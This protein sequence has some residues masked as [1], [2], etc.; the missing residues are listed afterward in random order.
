M[1]ALATQAF[2]QI[3]SEGKL[4]SL[5]VLQR[6]TAAAGLARVVQAEL[7]VLEIIGTAARVVASAAS[8]QAL[9]TQVLVTQALAMQVLAQQAPA[10]I[11]LVGK[12]AQSLPLQRKTV[13]AGLQPQVVQAAL[14]VLGKLDTAAWAEPAWEGGVRPA[15]T[16][17]AKDLASTV[18]P[19]ESDLHSP[20]AVKQQ[21]KFLHRQNIVNLQHPQQE[22]PAALLFLV[23]WA[24]TQKT[25]EPMKLP[26]GHNGPPRD[27]IGR[28][29]V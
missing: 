3:D 4:A 27:E 21:E 5:I 28:A 9:A 29:H 12:L 20:L 19:L 25:F 1:Q 14:T 18:L 16:E 11:D 24:K 13:V 6:E 23:A 7:T 17:L 15:S 22:D 26:S 10:L 2:A 8:M